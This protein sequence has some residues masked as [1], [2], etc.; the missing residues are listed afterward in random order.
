MTE[1]ADGQAGF[2]QTAARLR[3]LA[4]LDTFGD[5]RSRRS[6]W[7]KP[8]R[9]SRPCRLFAGRLAKSSLSRCADRRGQPGNGSSPVLLA[10]ISIS[11]C[12][13][14]LFLTAWLIYLA[15]RFADTIKLPAR[16]SDFAAPSLL[17]GTHDRVVGRGRGDFLSSMSRSPCAP[18][19]CRC[20]SSAAPW[21]H[22]AAFISS[23]I[24]R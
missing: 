15:D 16:Q 10:R 8:R 9:L 22:F 2:E 12:A 4:T 14:L 6:M 24:I 7:P 19:I 21:P 20:F 3:R 5:A 1:P 13:A 18:S 23:L 17:P 11:R